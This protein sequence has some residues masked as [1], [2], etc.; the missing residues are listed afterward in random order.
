[1]LFPPLNV[2]H[3][4]ISTFRSMCAVH[5][6][7][8]FC[9]YLISCSPGMLITHS[10]S[11]FKVVPVAPIITGITF[12]FTIHMSRISIVRSSSFI[13]FSATYLFTFPS[14]ESATSVNMHVPCLLS[15]IMTSGILVGMILLVCNCWFHN[16][17]TCEWEFC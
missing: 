1:M 14:P 4:C 7:A 10:L 17:I 15:Q 11:D 13:I 8:V 9:S 12:A 16:I 3:F 6:M 2:L 5:N